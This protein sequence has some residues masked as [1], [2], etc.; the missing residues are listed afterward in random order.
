M[1]EERWRWKLDTPEQF[2]TKSLT[3]LLASGGNK[4]NSQLYKNI[5]RGPIPR[6]FDSF[7]GRLAIAALTQPKFSSKRPHGWCQLRV[8]VLCHQ[9]NETIMHILVFC[10]FTQ[11]FW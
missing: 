10:G 7:F 4:Q 3:Q 9:S 11:S 5:W 2:T 8:G 1:V 6:R